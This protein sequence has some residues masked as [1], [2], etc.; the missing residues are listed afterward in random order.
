M[1]TDPP[2]D[3]TAEQ[4][5]ALFRKLDEGLYYMREGGK[6]HQEQ[7]KFGVDLLL[8]FAQQTRQDA[9]RECRDEINELVGKDSGNWNRAIVYAIAALDRLAS[10]GG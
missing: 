9:L 2:R 7:D 5:A 3:L 6:S 1:A 8:Q 10:E 4:A